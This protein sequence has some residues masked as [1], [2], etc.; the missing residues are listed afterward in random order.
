MT[1]N[2]DKWLRA[3][4]AKGIRTTQD[5]VGRHDDPEANPPKDRAGF[6]PV[7]GR[8]A[9]PFKATGHKGGISRQGA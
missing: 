1:N 2:K 8:S 4:Q 7:R 6:R 3:L 9:K 5:E